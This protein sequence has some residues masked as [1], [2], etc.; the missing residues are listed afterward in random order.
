MVLN[1]QGNQHGVLAVSPFT[2]TDPVTRSQKAAMVMFGVTPGSMSQIYGEV[3]FPATMD[4]ADAW[5]MLRNIEGRIEWNR[6]Q[7]INHYGANALLF[8]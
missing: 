8:L 7:V 4:F 6:A 5:R 1:E 3:H 2:F